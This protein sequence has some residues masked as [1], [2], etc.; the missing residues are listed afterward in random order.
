MI[1]DQTALPECACTQSTLHNQCEATTIPKGAKT[2]LALFAL[3]PN[4]AKHL[5]A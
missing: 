1:L 5:L 3:F 4:Q 2:H